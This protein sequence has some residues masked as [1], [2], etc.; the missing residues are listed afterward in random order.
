M[1]FTF[2][3]FSTASFFLNVKISVYYTP[4]PHLVKGGRKI[5]R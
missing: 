3:T 1:L 5:L 4:P 2:S